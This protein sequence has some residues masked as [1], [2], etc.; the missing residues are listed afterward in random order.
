MNVLDVRKLSVW[1]K[2]EEGEYSVLKGADF[3][4]GQGEIAGIVGESG[5]GKSTAMLA[6][7]GLLGENARAEYET[8]TVC[9]ERPV[10]GRN[11][12]MIFQDPLS[13]LNPTVKIGRQIT[14][15]VRQRTGCGRKAAKRRAEELLEMVGIR[16]ASMRMGQYPFELSGGMRQRVVIA[17]ALACEPKLIIADEPTTALDAA[18]QAQIIVL[19]KK[20]VR[21]TGTSLLLVSHDMGVTAA[22]CERVYVMREGRIIE[23]GSAE[24]IFYAPV[25]KY[26]KKLISRGKRSGKKK[27][28][29]KAEEG[30]ILLSLDH[31]TKEYDT[32][33]GIY[34]V[35]AVIRKGEI[36]ALVGESGSGKTTVA[37]ILSGMLRP[38]CGLLEYRG[39]TMDAGM[40]KSACRGRIQMVFQDPYAS[41]NPCL[42]VGQALREALAGCGDMDCDVQE[43]AGQMLELVGLA[44]EDAL[45]Y[46]S[47][48]SG[49]ER[50]RVGIARALITEPEI[51][52]CDEA[53]SS[54]DAATREQILELLLKIQKER[55]IACLFIS[56]DIRMVRRISDRIGVMFAGRMVESGRTETVL[57]DPWHPYTKQLIRSVPEAD[58]LRASKIPA[59]PV[60]DISDPSAHR[61]R[62][63][64]DAGKFCPYADRC[65]FSMER[66]TLEIPDESAFGER[67]VACFLYSEE[68]RGKRGEGY[69]MTS[70]I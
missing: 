6:V 46:P 49:G 32:R 10:P 40:R 29:D 43:K 67:N 63:K 25:D 62:R 33:E 26:T 16:N 56:H 35:S 17:I 11:A 34:D 14:E 58:P 4:V 7:M 39:R 64:R 19:L 3:S 59:A 24:D 21:E 41:L 36:F 50:Q 66:C 9:G 1:Y 55:R 8:L 5:A 61:K 69:G 12:A 20:I 48:L 42:S 13:S 23:S 37:R 57:K 52:V 18:V 22:L 28:E 15:T 68:Y 70:Q 53:L 45:K 30:E 54:L 38:D 27:T 2:K 51:L 65:G 47:D 44:K 31:V 60:F